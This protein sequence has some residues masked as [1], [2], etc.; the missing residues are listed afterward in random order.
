MSIILINLIFLFIIIILEV[1]KIRKIEKSLR[2]NSILPNILLF[3]TSIV[4]INSFVSIVHMMILRANGIQCF[5][6]SFSPLLYVVFIIRLLR[7]FS[8]Y[9]EIRNQN[10]NKVESN[11]KKEEI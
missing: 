7:I 11:K 8:L 10:S 9:T 2:K 1:I 4:Q 3:I 6:Y 5:H